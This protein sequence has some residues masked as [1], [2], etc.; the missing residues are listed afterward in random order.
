MLV[1]DESGGTPEIVGIA[2]H[3]RQRRRGIGKHMI[4]HA[5]ES[6]RL[7]R[8][9]AQTDDDAVGFYRAC[10]FSIEKVI[11]AYPDGIAVRPC[12]LC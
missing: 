4:R 7:E 6:E 8:V 1:M 3:G 5:M 9:G 12:S 2:V 10:G 11:K